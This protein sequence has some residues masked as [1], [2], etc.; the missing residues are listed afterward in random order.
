M[1][2]ES[3]KTFEET[4]TN[5]FYQEIEV[6]NKVYHRSKVAEGKILWDKICG[7][8]SLTPDEEKKL[9]KSYQL[10]LKLNRILK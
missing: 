1:K 9:E 7:W 8:N 3:I 2:N 6:D 10:E 4:K 5:Y